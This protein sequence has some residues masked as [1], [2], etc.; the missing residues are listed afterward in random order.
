MKQV[1]RMQ[2]DACQ[3]SDKTN[4][5]FEIINDL[6]YYN[7]RFLNRLKNIENGKNS[8]ENTFSVDSHCIECPDFG[9]FYIFPPFHSEYIKHGTFLAR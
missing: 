6:I 2:L 7:Q 5:I 9:Q 4:S 3:A 1:F 8:S